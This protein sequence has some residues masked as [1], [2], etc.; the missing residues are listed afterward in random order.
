MSRLMQS[1]LMGRWLTR[2]LITGTISPGVLLLLNFVVSDVRINNQQLGYDSHQSLL[3]LTNIMHHYR[4]RLKALLLL[5]YGIYHT[6]IAS[7]VGI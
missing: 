6:A 2:R 7:I 5:R 1:S 4:L 3:S